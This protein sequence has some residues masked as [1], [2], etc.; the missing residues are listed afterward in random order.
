MTKEEIFKQIIN[1]IKEVVPELENYNIQQTDSLK[2]LGANSVDRAEIITLMM[3]SL[4]INIPRIDF[5]GAKNI[6][7]LVEI[8]YAKK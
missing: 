5:F 2:D 8:F 3:E 6:K 7:D 4:H 1:H